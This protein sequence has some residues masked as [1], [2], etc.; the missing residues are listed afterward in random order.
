MADNVNQ[1]KHYTASCIECIDAI[2]AAL[3]PDGFRAYCIGNVLKYNWRYRLKN[4]AEDL[5]KARVYQAWA[6]A[7]TAADKPA[8]EASGATQYAHEAPVPPA[9]AALMER[10]SEEPDSLNAGQA[11]WQHS[12]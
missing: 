10:Q 3:G 11:Y 6:I 4:G 2:E 5:R 8:P 12:A 7:G 9:L 1:P